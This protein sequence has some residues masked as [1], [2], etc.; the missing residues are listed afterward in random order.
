MKIMTAVMMIQMKNVAD[1]RVP[2]LHATQVL[3]EVQARAEIQVHVEEAQARVEVQV[4]KE[5]QVPVEEVHNPVLH[6]A[7]VAEAI[8]LL[9]HAEE[10]ALLLLMAEDI[11]EINMEAELQ[12]NPVQ[13]EEVLQEAVPGRK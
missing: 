4:L 1:L 6:E 7:A 3:A 10:A 9:L 5:V 8:P 12:V 11:G 13:E 2:D